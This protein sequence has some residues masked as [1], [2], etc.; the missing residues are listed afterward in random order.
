MSEYIERDAVL[1]NYLVTDPRGTFASCYSI[2]KFVNRLPAADVRPVVRGVWI[3]NDY[4]FNRCSECGYEF[5]HPEEKTTFCPGCGSNMEPGS[6][7]EM[8]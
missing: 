3:E 5:D 2:L 7:E 1:E 4:A 6:G 8:R